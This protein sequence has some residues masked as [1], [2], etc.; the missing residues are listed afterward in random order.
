MIFVVL[1]LFFLPHGP[2]LHLTP[3]IPNTTYSI[4]LFVSLEEA[5][6]S[7]LQPN[8]N[9]GFVAIATGKQITPTLV[10]FQGLHK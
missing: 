7:L 5:L 1:S 8:I 6:S 3:S 2:L 10:S 9:K 4:V